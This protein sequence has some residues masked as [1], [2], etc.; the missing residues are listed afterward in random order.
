MAPRGMMTA[1]GSWYCECPSPA[2]AIM[3][4]VKKEGKNRGRWCKLY[5]YTP[6]LSDLLVITSNCCYFSLCMLSN[7]RKKIS[8]HMRSPIRKEVQFLPLGI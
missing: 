1:D 3:R 2:R 5:P 7:E 4:Q 6:I 8:L